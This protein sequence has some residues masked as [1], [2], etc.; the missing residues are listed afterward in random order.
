MKDIQK[1]IKEIQ[2][3]VKSVLKKLDTLQKQTK[4]EREH[5]EI[6]TES[7]RTDLLDNLETKEFFL[8]NKAK[9]EIEA[10]KGFG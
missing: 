7:L 4:Q 9:R 6:E 1:T 2:K 5:I 3:N 8:K 10:N